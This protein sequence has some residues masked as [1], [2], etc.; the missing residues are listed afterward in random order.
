MHSG[1]LLALGIVL[2]GAL[3]SAVAAQETRVYRTE[4]SRAFG[5]SFENDDENR[6]VIGITTSSSGSMRD[7]LGVL[8]GSI[9]SGGP[10]EKA[11]LEE[12]NRI[13]AI[14]GVNLRLAAA[15]AGDWDMSSVMSRRFTRE[16]AKLKAGDEIDLRV[17]SNGQFRNV[18]IKTIAYEDLYR[19]SRTRTTRIDDED[20]AVLG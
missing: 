10:A 18:K 15:D 3:P 17:Y 13:A 9:T 2:A 20:R 8:I 7:T 4:P 16:M 1:M 12:G 6:A 11:G 5:F 14:N 19:A